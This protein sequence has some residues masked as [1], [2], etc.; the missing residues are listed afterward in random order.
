M[1]RAVAD[2]L[3]ALGRTRKGLTFGLT[4]ILHTWTRELAFHPHVHV[5]V[6]AGG[7]A[8]EGSM[9]IRLKHRYLSRE[10]CWARCFAA[11]C[12]PPWGPIGTLMASRSWKA[13]PMADWW[14]R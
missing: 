12:W 13:P 10:P 7:L 4:L 6:S 11:R 8:L 5:L 1:L 14:H 3:L 9:F 2:T